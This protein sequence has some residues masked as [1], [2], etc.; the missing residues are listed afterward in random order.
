MQQS[1]QRPYKSAMR[2]I[3][4]NEFRLKKRAKYVPKTADFRIFKCKKFSCI[5]FLFRRILDWQS[6]EI[7]L[8][9]GLTTLKNFLV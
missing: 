1:R 3:V 9:K 8:T 5:F 4:S 2:D 7:P 6:L